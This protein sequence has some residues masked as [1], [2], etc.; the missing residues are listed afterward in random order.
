MFKLELGKDEYA[1][2]ARL[3]PALLIYLPLGVA[4]GAWASIAGTSLIL[5]GILTV[6][7]TL[8]LASLL[9]QFGRDRG[10]RKEA[11]LYERWGG[12]PSTIL[13]RYGAKAFNP[14]TLGRYHRRL[15]D[16]LPDLRLPSEADETADLAKCDQV[17]EACGDYLLSQTRDTTRFRLLFQENMNF[18]FRRNLWA[19]KP[20]GV[21]PNSW[22]RYHTRRSLR[23]GRNATG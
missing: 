6:G 22:L 13:L 9:G 21:V 16:L 15:G 10:K 18:G 19:M 4:I 11:E 17:Y 14:H 2:Q 1:R 23:P 5:T 7:S 3:M 12:K 20:T 8:G